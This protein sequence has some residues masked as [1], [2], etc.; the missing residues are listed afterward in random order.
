MHFRAHYRR[1]WVVAG[2]SI[3]ATAVFTC[4]WSTGLHFFFTPPDGAPHGAWWDIAEAEIPVWFSWLLA[5]PILIAATRKY[6]LWSGRTL[7]GLLA[8]ALFLPVFTAIVVALT[9]GGRVLEG[10]YPASQAYTLWRFH[11]F[12]GIGQ[13]LLNYVAIAAIVTAIDDAARER[14]LRADLNEL[15]LTQ[16]LEQLRPHFLFNCLHGAASLIDSDP[17][18]ARQMLVRLG[19]LLRLAL[20]TDDRALVPL[21]QELE[22]LNVYYS[23]QQLRFGPNRL[24]FS[25]DVPPSVDE[26]LVPKFSLQLLAENSIRHVLERRSGELTVTIL[27]IRNVSTLSVIVADDGPGFPLQPSGGSGLVNLGERLRLAFG[28]AG[29]LRVGNGDN[30]GARVEIFVPLQ[31]SQD[32]AF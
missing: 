27:A 1:P 30:G 26:V 32:L 25:I 9:I 20:A 16:L 7:R 3:A 29:G 17:G 31:W 19:D 13:N 10:V 11:Y 12:A 23:L 8:H 24:A 4:I 14:A 22:W 18:R 6:P 21:A 2:W 15:R 5:S 28:A